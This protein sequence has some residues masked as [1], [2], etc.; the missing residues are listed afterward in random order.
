MS[1]RPKRPGGKARTKGVPD[2][3]LWAEIARHVRPLRPQRGPTIESADTLSALP[4]AAVKAEKSRPRLKPAAPAAARPSGASA[5]P[6]T[7]IDRRT[8][9]RLSRGET[10][11]DD[12]IDLHGL[13]VEA[14]RVALRG[15]LAAARN[16]GSRLVLV[17]TGKG[18][19]PFTQHTL[20]GT[21][22]FHAPER[23]GRL[24]RLVVEWLAE[25]EFRLHVS[26]FQPAHPRHGGGG[27]LYVRL[28][29]AKERGD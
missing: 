16:R 18:A 21:S 6:L 3:E 15:F 9:R 13:S 26:G 29:R 20:H 1:D 14:A 25:P 27:A 8:R 5:L 24:R 2:F 19:S 10:D 7:G 4:P 12:R 23:Q 22:H 17:I 11:I 28:R